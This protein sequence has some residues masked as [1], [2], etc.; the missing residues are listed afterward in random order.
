ME[1][2]GEGESEQMPDQSTSQAQ[3]STRVGLMQASNGCDAADDD[4]GAW[5]GVGR[6]VGGA[7]DGVG[8]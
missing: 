2:E 4:E 7:L 3:A 5:R 6:G 8:E 1:G